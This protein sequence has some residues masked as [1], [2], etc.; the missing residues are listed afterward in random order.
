MPATTI[1]RALR[2]LSRRLSLTESVVLID[3]ALHKGV[4]PLTEIKRLNIRAVE[5]AEPATESPME[6][7]LRMVLVLGGLPRPQ[8][9]VPLRD[10]RGLFLGRPDLYYAEQRLGIEYDGGTHRDSLVSDN[11]RQNRLLSAGIQL[12]RFTAEDVFQHPEFLVAQVGT[13]LGA[14]MRALE[15]IDTRVSAPKSSARRTSKIDLAADDAP[16]D[17]T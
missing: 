17:E 9:Q 14:E 7:R 4:A 13:L 16:S 1:V 10:S 6:T 12:L 5:F 11:R 8:V 3:M 15:S 2:D